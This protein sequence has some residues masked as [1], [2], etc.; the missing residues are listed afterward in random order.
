MGAR[1]RNVDWSSIQIVI[2][3]EAEKNPHNPYA[4]A[5]QAQRDQVFREIARRVLLRRAGRRRQA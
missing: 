3:P 1:R 5:S 2:E 4:M